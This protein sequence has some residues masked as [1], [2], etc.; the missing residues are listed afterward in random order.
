[1]T[2]KNKWLCSPL[3]L[4]LAVELV[5]EFIV[6]VLFLREPGGSFDPCSFAPVDGHPRSNTAG[7][8]L[9]FIQAVYSQTLETGRTRI[10][11]SCTC[12]RCVLPAQLLFSELTFYPSTSWRYRYPCLRDHRLQ[13]QERAANQILGDNDPLECHP[14]RCDAILRRHNFHSVLFPLVH[15]YHPGRWHIIRSQVL[16]VPYSSRL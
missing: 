9:T 2:G 13:N 14:A 10:R 11:Q 16:T 6:T 1:M 8:N 5:A 12:F 3:V 15:V 7:G 4:L